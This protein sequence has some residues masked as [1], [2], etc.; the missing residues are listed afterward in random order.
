MILY[1]TIFFVEIVINF[2]KQ[3]LDDEGLTKYEL[4]ETIAVRYIQSGFLVDVITL[5]PWGYIFESYGPKAG[6]LWVIKA[7]RIKTLQNMMSN[8]NILPPVKTLITNL[9]KKSMNDE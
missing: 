4:P 6:V 7:I 9:Q 3:D 5:I 1:E 8:K 2:I